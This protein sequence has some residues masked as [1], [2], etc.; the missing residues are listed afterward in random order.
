[1]FATARNAGGGGRQNYCS[2]GSRMNGFFVPGAATGLPRESKPFFTA[3]A[4]SCCCVVAPDVLGM[5]DDGSGGAGATGGSV[6]GPGGNSSPPL[7]PQAASDSKATA[8]TSAKLRR[9]PA[10]GLSPDSPDARSRQPSKPD[11]GGGIVA[12]TSS[13]GF[14][15]P[16]PRPFTAA[17]STV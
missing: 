12:A 8:N 16:L 10:K 11:F 1:M 3:A 2:I 9:R 4:S 15:K 5:N 6:A 17:F 13:K 7:R 14:T